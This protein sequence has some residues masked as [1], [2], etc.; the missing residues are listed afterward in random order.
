MPKRME[1]PYLDELLNLFE[2]AKEN[3]YDKDLDNFK[4][5]LM[6]RPQVI[7]FP[8]KAGSDFATGGLV[9]PLT[10]SQIVNLLNAGIGQFFKQRQ[11]LS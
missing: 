7:P 11:A 8:D 6:N 2:V 10:Q 4:Y 3:G 5:D 9:G 1:L